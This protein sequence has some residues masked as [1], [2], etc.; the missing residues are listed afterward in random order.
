MTLATEEIEMFL[1]KWRERGCKDEQQMVNVCSHSSKPPVARGVHV[2]YISGDQGNA[3][4]GLG[5]RRS[6][7]H[8]PP[9]ILKGNAS[10]RVPPSVRERGPAEGLT[11]TEA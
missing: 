2:H 5:T 4:K 11:G 3:G 10:L 6:L 7:Y 1:M 8:R 9:T